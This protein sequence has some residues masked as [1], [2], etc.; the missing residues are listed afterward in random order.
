MGNFP[1]ETAA[2]HSSQYLSVPDPNRNG[3]GF[4]LFPERVDSIFRY[5]IVRFR[6]CYLWA[7]MQLCGELTHVAKNYYR[8]VHSPCPFL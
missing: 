8:E 1:N 7:A 6:V 2:C 5:V 3:E 4:S